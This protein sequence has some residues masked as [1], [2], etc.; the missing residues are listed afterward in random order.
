MYYVDVGL[1]FR[2]AAYSLNKRIFKDIYEFESEFYSLNWTYNW[3]GRFAFIMHNSKKISVELFGQDNSLLTATLSRNPIFFSKLQ[4]ISESII[5][6]HDHVIADGRNVGDSIMID[7]D[8][9]FQ[10]TSSIETRTERRL[11]DYRKL[12]VLAVSHE[13]MAMLEERDS[14]DTSRQYNP[15]VSTNNYITIDNSGTTNE[16]VEKLHEYIQA[17]LTTS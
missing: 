16:T 3:D 17:A 7:A 12:G 6:A 9:R 4:N 1:I 10:I 14:L 11:N 5:S 15:M 13:V 8:R 2:F